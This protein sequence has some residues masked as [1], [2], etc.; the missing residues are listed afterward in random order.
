MAS[1]YQSIGWHRILRNTLITCALPRCQVRTSDGGVIA[2][3]DGPAGG[4]G[5]G[6]GGRGNVIDVEFREVD[7]NKK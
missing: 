5:G 3:D 1:I 4:G 7:S 2:V 6:S